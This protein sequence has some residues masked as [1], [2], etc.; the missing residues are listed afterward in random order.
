[1]R[2]RV[3]IENDSVKFEVDDE[4]IILEVLLDIRELL[5]KG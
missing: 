2:S 5:I 3:E 4:D 1:M